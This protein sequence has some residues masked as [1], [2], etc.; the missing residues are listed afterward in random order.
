MLEEYRDLIGS[1]FDWIY[2]PFL[3]LSFVVCKD[4]NVRWTLFILGAYT[5]FAK[6][7]VLI[8]M[9]IF[10][11][12]GVTFH[13]V[14]IVI[15]VFLIRSLIIFRPIVSLK[16]GGVFARIPVFG[17]LVEVVLPAVYPV[18]FYMAELAIRRVCYA[19][20]VS[21]SLVVCHYFMFYAG[22]FEAG[23]V[24]EMLGIYR[25]ALWDLALAVH[26]VGLSLEL[27]LLLALIIAGCK[28]RFLLKV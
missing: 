17:P 1:V 16:I 15:H 2:W 28:N 26:C 6:F 14:Q 7:M 11:M 12:P 27:L 10:E 4:A 5:S 24:Y 9:P 18:K 25:L 22:A 8:V 19:F 13:V 3:F 23:A 21:H 20:V